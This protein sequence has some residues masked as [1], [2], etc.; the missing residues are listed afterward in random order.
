MTCSKTYTFLLDCCKISTRAEDYWVP[1]PAFYASARLSPLPRRLIYTSPS[2]SLWTPLYL[3]TQFNDTSEKLCP[4]WATPLTKQSSDCSPP[5]HNTQQHTH[6]ETFH[7]IALWLVNFGFLYLNT[8][9]TH[10]IKWSLTHLYI[11]SI[12]QSLLHWKYSIRKCRL[13]YI[14]LVMKILYSKLQST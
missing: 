8:L 10:W 9:W 4:D 5:P 3:N 2:V 1:W 7:H 6:S 12:P 13:L 11:A 14:W